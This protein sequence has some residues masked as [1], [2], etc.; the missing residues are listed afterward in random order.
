MA[1][2]II[3]DLF[4]SVKDV[5]S[6]VVVDKDKRDQVN[7]ELRRIEDQAQ[8]RLDAQVQGQIEVNKVEAANGSVFVA[9]W[10]PAIGWVGAVALL[11]A[12][13][14][15]PAIQWIG[16]MFGH[17][18]AIPDPNFSE[19]MPLIFAILGIGGMRS[20]EKIKGVATNDYTATPST[21]PTTVSVDTKKGA[22]EVTTPSVAPVEPVAKKKRWSL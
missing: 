22:V 2:P 19:L 17:N 11:W 16:Q 8:A 3:G 10:R 12:F 18:I 7:L 5:V 15:G 1:I 6:E 13:V 20:F 14:V 21:P 4:N 9:G